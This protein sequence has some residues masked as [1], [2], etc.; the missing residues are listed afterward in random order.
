[1]ETKKEKAQAVKS[2]NEK[3]TEMSS[4]ATETPKAEEKRDE[5]TLSLSQLLEK[6]LTEIKRKKMLVDRRDIF[7]QK[8]EAL[9]NCL[10]DLKQEQAEGNFTTDNYALVFSRKNGGYRDEDA[11]KISNPAL[12]EKFLVSLKTEIVIAINSIETELMKD[13]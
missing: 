10:S 1:M 5:K 9:E 6:Q 8:S 4:T 3:V 13:L 12:M 11:F 7:L 2:V